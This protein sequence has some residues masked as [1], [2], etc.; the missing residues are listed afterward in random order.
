VAGEIGT[1][2]AG[3]DRGVANA[4]GKLKPPPQKG[5]G[6]NIDPRL[7]AAMDDAD[8]AV[9]NRRR[10]VS[11]K[12][13]KTGKF[14]TGMRD[15]QDE[16][17]RNV[18]GVGNRAMPQVPSGGGGGAV[19]SG[20]GVPAGGGGMPA[21]APAPSGLVNIDPNLLQQLVEASN[22]QGE[23]ERANGELP[24]M[25]R[26]PFS[27]NAAKTPQSPDPLDVSQVSLEKVG[28]GPLSSDEIAA[29]IDQA[30]TI[31]GIPNDPA[32]RE[33]WQALY[34]HMAAHESSN[35]PDAVNDSDT[36]AI[37]P[38]V[39]DG[40]HSNS[41]RGPWQCIPSTFA[42]YHMGGTSTSIYDPV[43][44]AAASMNYVMHTYHVSP[45]GENLDG[46]AARQGV[47]T[48]NYVGY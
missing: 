29:V 12:T 38:I 47:G 35:D 34:Q 39:A 25:S 11:E 41:S 21:S 46:F 16:G 30:A 9:N 24:G 6:G 10:K 1:D 20:G 22:E 17:D 23:K 8:E 26:D 5:P 45:D 27:G 19:P 15:L 32:I 13:D 44:S 14:N 7:G 2:Y 40:S 43:A 18:R 42:A 48:A 28:S 37:G 33:Q 4:N 31:N 3:V 36:N